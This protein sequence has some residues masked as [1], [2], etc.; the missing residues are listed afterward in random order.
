MHPAAAGA[1]DRD[2]L[3]NSYAQQLAAMAA[4]NL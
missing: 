4:P 1:L 2:V 3:D